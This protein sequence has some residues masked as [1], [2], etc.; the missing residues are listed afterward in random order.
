MSA[1]QG[2]SVDLKIADGIESHFGGQTWRFDAF[3]AFSPIAIIGVSAASAP[4]GVLF[5]DNFNTTGSSAL[6]SE[7]LRQRRMLLSRTR[8]SVSTIPPL[9]FRQ[10]REPAIRWAFACGRIS[11]AARRAPSPRRPGGV[12]S[13]LSVSPTG[14]SFGAAIKPPSTPGPTSTALQT[15]VAWRITRTPKAAPITSCSPSEHRVPFQ[16]WSAT[17]VWPPTA[18]WTASAS[19]PPVTAVFPM[20]IA[21]TPHP[22]PSPREHP[23][24]TLPVPTP[25]SIKIPT[26]SIPP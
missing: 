15:P 25:P 11:P 17:R 22:A 21:S 20:T 7:R 9:G 14:M 16:S 2:T 19:L 18:S 26:P 10:R 12:L 3:G 6:D 8:F 13:G 24:T 23:A 4:A 1:G 5:S